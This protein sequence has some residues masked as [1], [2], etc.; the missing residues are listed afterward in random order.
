MRPVLLTTVA[1]IALSGAAFAQTQAPAPTPRD[2]AAQ[3]APPAKPAEQTVTI[4][5]NEFTAN[6]LVGMRIYA[7]RPATSA[8]ATPRTTGSTAPANP[9]N[10][11]PAPA[12]RSDAAT[13]PAPRADATAMPAG[14]PAAIS[15][16]Q[17][18]AMRERY[19]NIGDV[20]DLVMTPDGRIQHVVLGV[21]GF[22]GIGEKNV[23]LNWNELRLM[24]NSDG[25]LFAIVM[26][27]KEQL[28]AMPSFQ[29]ERR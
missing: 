21:G 5:E 8:E 22:L 9:A 23:A 28:Q 13:A 4:R 25:K 15:D 1:A 12:S 18:R 29:V 24:R 17:W 11:A 10:T 14:R 16:E 7:P 20:N 19:E 2:P 27:T 26:K 3:S 6:N